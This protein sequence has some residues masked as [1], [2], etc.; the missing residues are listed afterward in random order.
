MSGTQDRRSARLWGAR[1][2]AL[3]ISL[4][5]TTVILL[6]A[7]GATLLGSVVEQGR[8]AEF[9]DGKYGAFAGPVM[10]LVG[11]DDV[12]HSWWFSVLLVLVAAQILLCTVSRFRT[13]WT[14]A[15]R[16][17]SFAPEGAEEILAEGAVF[18]LL[19]V[20]A[21][22][23]GYRHAGTGGAEGGPEAEVALARGVVL[24]RGRLQPLG[25]LLLHVSLLVLLVGM[26]WDL[27]QGFR[28]SLY[29]PVGQRVLEQNTNRLLE[30]VEL[31]PTF[32]QRSGLEGEAAYELSDMSA[33]VAIYEGGRL[34][35]RDDLSVG[36]DMG[37]DRG[38]LSLAPALDRSQVVLRVTS[39]QGTSVV[40]RLSFENSEVSLRGGEGLVLS[41][42]DFAPDAEEVDGRWA[43]RSPE[44]LAPLLAASVVRENPAGSAAVVAE[45]DLRLGTSFEAE[46]YTIA[47]EDAVYM[48]VVV[49]SSRS[50]GLIVGVGIVANLLGV[51]LS[52]GF[53]FRQ[54]RLM[55]ADGGVRI[56]GYAR[57]RNQP[58]AEE[59]RRLVAAVAGSREDDFGRPGVGAGGGGA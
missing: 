19:V 52:L 5:V 27:S 9:Y 16:P 48:P 49:V 37:F 10:R 55:P 53:S 4:R 50:A 34:L 40:E 22:R 44:L 39:P 15:F 33:V 6:L 25:F 32:V 24:A 35:T 59:I 28:A 7:F 11:A 46:G 38:R 17:G 1:V 31:T 42:L 43:R 8:G 57:R 45:A 12:F 58:L 29:L 3:F 36:F 21:R 14:Q 13:A 20:E 2:V 41:V 23:R 30:V 18:E 26:S 51:L 47:F 56:F 54:L